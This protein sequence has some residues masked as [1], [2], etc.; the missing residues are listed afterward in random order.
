V[1]RIEHPLSSN[2][3]SAYSD[4]FAWLENGLLGCLAG[5]T[6]VA[7]VGPD[8]DAS[9]A[10]AADYVFKV[11][12]TRGGCDLHVNFRLIERATEASIWSRCFQTPISGALTDLGHLA[13]VACNEIAS[14]RGVI[15]RA[16][17]TKAKKIA[18]EARE[19]HHHYALALA[20]ERQRDAPST[21]A[22]LRHIERSLELEPENARGWLLLWHFLERPFI[23]LG[24]PLTE[25]VSSRCR[26]ALARAFQTDPDDP[27]VLVNVCGER[28]RSG[29]TGG[30]AIALEKATQMGRTQADVMS[31]CANR[32][33][34]VAGDINAAREHLA[35]AHAL[36]PMVKDWLRFAT[37]RVNFFAA[38]FDAC[39]LATG[40]APDL[41]PLAI[42]RALSLAL[43]N[44]KREAKEA[45][46]SMRALFPR[47]D[48]EAY[49]NQLPITAVSARDMY[50]EAV[51][52]L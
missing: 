47:A 44:R 29:D 27:L 8:A 49:A 13:A 7:A 1:I 17:A 2:I 48:L 50:D 38:D 25:S 43:L 45:N 34:A 15:M 21:E 19:A 30:A 18:P 31:P 41:L 10:V 12:F 52:R 5:M 37:A 28:A 4:E 20:H 26:S 9:E 35:Q 40:R 6:D 16:E 23:L 11:R 33:A 3:V 42:F 14:W 46:R 32:Y 22:G 51:R 39:L 24:E 36:N